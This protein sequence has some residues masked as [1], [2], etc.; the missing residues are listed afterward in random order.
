MMAIGAY[1]AKLTLAKLTITKAAVLCVLCG[2]N[3]LSK[4]DKMSVRIP[5]VSFLFRDN[6]CLT[7]ARIMRAVCLVITHSVAK[8]LYSPKG[9]T[10]E[11]EK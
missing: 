4:L 5:C 7:C 10:K 2:S 9:Y 11:A 1:Q 6:Q 3:I 8:Y